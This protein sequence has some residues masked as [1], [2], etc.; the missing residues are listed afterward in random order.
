[1]A[2]VRCLVYNNS[3]CYYNFCGI[4]VWFVEVVFITI[5]SILKKDMDFF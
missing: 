4:I 1:M 5:E 2:F 3:C